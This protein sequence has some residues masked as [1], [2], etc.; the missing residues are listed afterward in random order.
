MK[1]SHPCKRMGFVCAPVMIGVALS[2]WTQAQSQPPQT[3]DLQQL[4]N[5]L[6]QLEQ[7]M[8]ELKGQINADQ[9]VY[10]DRVELQGVKPKFDMP[11]FSW[12]ARLIRRWGYA[13]FGGIFRKISWVDTK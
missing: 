1:S 5:K 9:G 7:E 13:R 8:N 3:S 2:I 11:D 10:A 6:Q 12:E 4:K